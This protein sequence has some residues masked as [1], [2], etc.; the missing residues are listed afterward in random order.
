M[1]RQ[2]HTLILPV[3]PARPTTAS[4]LRA[5]QCGELAIPPRIVVRA[6]LAGDPRLG[7]ASIMT[8]DSKTTGTLQAYGLIRVEV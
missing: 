3:A 1:N 4:R 5:W 2:D 8:N 7:A 6:A